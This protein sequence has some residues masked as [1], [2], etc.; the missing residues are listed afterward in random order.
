MGIKEFITGIM[1]KK[2]IK[3]AVKLILSAV[4]SVGVV[5]ALKVSGVEIHIDQVQ[6]EAGLTVAINSG[7]EMLRNYLKQKGVVIL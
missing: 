3:S 4:A 1:I 2:G 5:N 6:L 7:L